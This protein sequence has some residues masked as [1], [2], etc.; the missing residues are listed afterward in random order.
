MLKKIFN[1]YGYTFS[2]IKKTNLISDVIK[3][4]LSRNSCD[5]LVDVG[6]N[7]GD[8]SNE[9]VREFKKIFLI[10]PNPNLQ[11]AL[12]HR[13]KAKKNIKIFNHGIHNKNSMKKLYISGDTGSTLSSIK[14]QNKILKQN[15][16]KTE[17]I[18]TQN[19]K[20]L[21]LDKLLKKNILSNNSIFLKTDT[22][23]NELEV[24]KSLGTYLK[25]VKYIKCEM[26]IMALY[27]NQNSHW[28]IL[29]FFKENKYEPIFFENG[30]RDKKGNM[31]EYDIFLERKN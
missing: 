12:E 7:K 29:K 23:G 1:Y 15:L 17:I 28:E 21:R 22:Q 5:I 18:S 2:K 11:K 20:F 10:E 25:K 26:S 24:L 14:K 8:F 16:K 4:K 6:A 30:L 19:L 9:F 27:R 3:M 31:I 13:F